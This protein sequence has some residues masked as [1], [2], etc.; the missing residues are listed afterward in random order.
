MDASTT[1]RTH[2]YEHSTYMPCHKAC[3]ERF[4]EKHRE[5]SI[6][7]SKAWYYNLKETDPEKFKLMKDR[8]KEL[9]RI[10]YHKKKLEKI[11]ETEYLES[12]ITA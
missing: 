10:R 7:K 9:A 12:Q 6:A 11:A 2:K 5:T 1:T 3:Y 4:Y 8:Q